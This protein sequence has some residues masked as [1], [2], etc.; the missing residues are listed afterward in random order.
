[1]G[2][3][4]S[5]SYPPGGPPADLLIEGYG[6]T[7]GEAFAGAALG[8]YN[9]ITPLEG[10]S[11]REEFGVDVEG[12]DIESL[13]LNFLDELLFLSDT[14]GLI[15]KTL[16]VEVDETKFKA[17]AKCNGERFSASTHVV[18]ASIKAVTYHMMKIE[19]KGNFW[20]TR[21]VFDT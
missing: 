4:A 1:M 16:E 5:F 6:E 8:M 10:V 13:L 7:I 11:E 2:V 20:I 18:G 17:K 3:M 14:E 19:K 9:A 15:A 12:I 21:V